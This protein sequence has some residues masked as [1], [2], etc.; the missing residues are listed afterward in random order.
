MADR[1]FNPASTLPD[2]VRYFD[3]I[4]SCRECGKTASGVLRGPRNDNYGPY[5]KRCADKRL[6]QAKKERE[7]VDAWNR[8]AG[9]KS[10]G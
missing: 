8:R 1:T 9:E 4:G 3:A 7:A 2:Q 5:C 6:L 10:D